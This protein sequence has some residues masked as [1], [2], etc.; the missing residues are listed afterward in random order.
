MVL[1]GR[2]QIFRRRC[3]DSK[4]GTYKIGNGFRLAL[5]HLLTHAASVLP[6]LFVWG[7]KMSGVQMSKLVDKGCVPLFASLVRIQQQLITYRNGNVPLL[8]FRA[9]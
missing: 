3:L 6:M 4:P 8:G 7:A 5:Y 2:V 9:L 1:A